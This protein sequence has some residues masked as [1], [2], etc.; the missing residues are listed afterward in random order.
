MRAIRRR[1]HASR[2]AGVT[3]NTCAHRRRGISE[4]SAASHSR[5]AGLYRTGAVSCLRCTAFS[6]RSTSSSASFVTSR[7]SSTAGTAS[8]FRATWYISETITRT[9]V[10]AAVTAR[11]TRLKQQP[12]PP[13]EAWRVVG[14]AGLFWSPDWLKK[15]VK[16]SE[17]SLSLE[18]YRNYSNITDKNYSLWEI[19][20][21]LSLRT[22]RR[23]GSRS[24]QCRALRRCDCR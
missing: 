14:G 6:C 1:C 8:S 11:H 19:G 3:G 4:D 7:R 12:V 23:S 21:T 15:L 2:V 17:L 20:P 5:S 9:T 13:R 18:Y 16:R 10:T 22:I 24:F